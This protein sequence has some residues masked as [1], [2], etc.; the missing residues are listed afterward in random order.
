MQT[1]D[2]AELIN[3]ESITTQQESKQQKW[4]E[5][6]EEKT[7]P[8]ASIKGTSIEEGLPSIMKH[9]QSTRVD[10]DSST[11]NTGRFHQRNQVTEVQAIPREVTDALRSDSLN[12][13]NVLSS[14]ESKVSF[15]RFHKNQLHQSSIN[16]L[17]VG[18]SINLPQT[19]VMDSSSKLVGSETSQLLS[20]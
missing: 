13:N 16:K 11:L 3:N 17:A 8:Y 12:Q 5:S 6:L 9:N 10:H 4:D 19:S 1:D 7:S 18:K 20:H 2:F 15:K 14:M